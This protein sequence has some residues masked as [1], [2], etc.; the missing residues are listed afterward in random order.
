[1][2]ARQ[3]E[4]YLSTYLHARGAK[5][6]LPI[7]GNFELTPRCNFSCPMCY[8][9]LNQD[10]QAAQREL[11]AAQWIEL[12]RQARDA[13]MVFVLL[14][15]GEP[16]IR[17]DFF[18]IYEAMKAM[19]LMVSINSNGSMLSG[20]VR[21]RLLENPPLRINISLYGGCR[22]TYRT[23][24]GRDAFDTV[25]ENIRA[26]KEAG[27][28][29]RLNLSITPWNRQDIGRI[30]HIARALDVPVKGSAYMYPPIRVNGQR[31]GCGDRLTA[32]EAA[33]CSVE[34][35]LLRFTPEEFARRAQ[36]MK[37]LCNLERESC[38]ADLDEG[39]GC[40]AGHTSF[41][42]TW[43][44][45]MLPC[46]MMPGPAV[47]PLETGF[48]LAWHRL[49][50]ETRRISAP[51]QCGSCPKKAICPACA[52]VRITE[53]GAFDRVP[54]YMCR[55]M[56]ETVSQTWQAWQERSSAGYAD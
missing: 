49:R 13:G 28:D 48:D 34:W 50:E 41:W 23:M 5:L 15:G 43:E 22:E 26:L 21:R 51:A 45:R 29:V 32:E 19:G 7:A 33:Q 24:C 42:M 2:E 9:H 17:R 37:A 31:F 11:T 25:V 1:M 55:M 36:S 4:P 10:A 16:F 35:D 27:V 20:D 12:A 3:T 53:T 47:S 30:Y 54:E 44:G 56:G 18:E 6:G 8:V 14:T 39:V 52:A 40:R 46:G 38:V